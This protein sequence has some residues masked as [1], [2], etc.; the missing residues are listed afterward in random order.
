M[1]ANL[2]YTLSCSEYLRVSKIYHYIKH[3][4]NLQNKILKTKMFRGKFL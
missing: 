2:S 3:K 4:I 1:E